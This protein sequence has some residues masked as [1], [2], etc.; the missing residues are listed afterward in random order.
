MFSGVFV[1]PTSRSHWIRF[2]QLMPSMRPQISHIQRTNT[3]VYRIT[4]VLSSYTESPNYWCIVS[5]RLA[6][7][8]RALSFDRHPCPIFCL[9]FCLSEP[10]ASGLP[11]FSVTVSGR[12][13]G[14][15]LDWI[16][17]SSR[18]RRVRIGGSF[19]VNSR[20]SAR[21]NLLVVSAHGPKGCSPDAIKNN[22]FKTCVSSCA[23][24]WQKAWIL[25]WVDCPRTMRI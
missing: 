12:A 10:G 25:E 19:E 16:P 7:K 6:F 24:L 4:G 23:Q 13:R 22:Y 11:G 1:Q 2:Q 8:T 17:F 9:K 5:K 20:H 21:L 15:L 18:L 3:A 14:R